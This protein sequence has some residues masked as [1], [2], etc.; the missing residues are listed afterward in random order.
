[1]EHIKAGRVY[2]WHKSPAVYLGER[3]AVQSNR[4]STP[5]FPLQAR[6]SQATQ[7]TRDSVNSRATHSLPT[8]SNVGCKAKYLTIWRDK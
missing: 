7:A 1:V 6:C 5:S 3:G 8:A 2:K 4:S